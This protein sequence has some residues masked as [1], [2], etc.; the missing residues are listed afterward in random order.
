M[1]KQGGFTLIELMIVVAIIGILAAI[2]VPQYQQFQRKA[3]FTEVISATGAFK[4]A[5]ELCIQNNNNSATGCSANKSGDGW[6]IPAK[7]ATSG[8]VASVD[9]ADG[10]IT[11]IATKTDGL[12]GETIVYKPDLTDTTKILWVKDTTTSSCSTATPAIC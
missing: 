9:V 5:V 7:T 6:S 10:V 2:A 4:S 12:N 8:H 3:R 11:A 1:K